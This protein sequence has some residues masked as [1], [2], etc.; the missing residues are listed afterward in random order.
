VVGS[1][2]NLPNGTV[3]GLPGLGHDEVPG[4]TVTSSEVSS[5]HDA[6]Q[7]SSTTNVASSSPSIDYG[8]LDSLGR[9]TGIHA[10]ITPD[11]LGTGTDASRGIRPAGFEGG[12]AG[13]A[14]GHLLGKQLGGSG[15]ARAIS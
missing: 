10:E 8:E 14:R 1:P 5:T 13:Q 4:Q 12:A 7:G 9:P 11:M 3:D 6:I 2:L 15:S